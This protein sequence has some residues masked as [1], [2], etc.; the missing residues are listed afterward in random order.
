MLLIKKAQKQDTDAFIQLIEENKT[1][2]Y[3]VAKSYLKN[4]EDIAD[5]M[6]DTVLSAFEHIGELR[7]VTFFKTWLTRILIN[8]CNDIIRKQSRMVAME[9]A[10]EPAGS[11]IESDYEFYDLL[12]ELPEKDRTVFLLYYGEGFNT[13]EIS[14]M[15]GW[16]ENT[17]KSRLQRG[18]KKLEQAVSF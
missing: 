9:E 5:A 1:A 17:V 11:L 18:R 4:E 16:N 2:L 14:E 6:Q 3:K 7:S 10:E 15:M 8:H 12:R 13:R